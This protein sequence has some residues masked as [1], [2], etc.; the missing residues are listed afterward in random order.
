VAALIGDHGINLHQ[1]Q[2]DTGLQ[3]LPPNNYTPKTY[4]GTLGT[5]LNTAG[6]LFP[7]NVKGHDWSQ[8]AQSYSFSLG[9]QRE[10]GYSTVIDAAFVGNLGRHLLQSVN[11]NQLPYGVRFLPTSVDP[12]N[13]RP[14]ADSFLTPYIGLGSITYA[15]PVGTS[16]Y[17]ALQMQANRRFSHGLEFKANWTWSK[18][19]DYG[20]GD[21]NGLPWQSHAVG[22]APGLS[23]EI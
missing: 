1:T 23:G 21:N 6:T 11:L 14:L 2:I 3:N 19:L 8:L 4:Y 10:V 20:S 16:N 12:T 7:S 22:S 9:V 17:Y 15:E 18:S 13:G 5:F